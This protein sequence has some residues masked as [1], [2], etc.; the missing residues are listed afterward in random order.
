[1][2]VITLAWA[3]LQKKKSKQNVDNDDAM[4]RLEAMKFNFSTIKA[5]TNNFSNA[6][7]LGEGGF[8]LVYKVS[9]PNGQ[10]FAVKRLFHKTEHT[11][12]QFKNEI[13]WWLSSNKSVLL[14]FK[15][16]VDDIGD[17]TITNDGATILKML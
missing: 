12:E 13:L 4:K 17:V 8:G 15:M 9:L 5:T 16:L 1:M 7:K 10:E 6:N 2:A 11:E 3:I 14:A